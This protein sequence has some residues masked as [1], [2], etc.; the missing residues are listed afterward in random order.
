MKE[1]TATILG[2]SGLIGGKLLELLL[3][4]NYYNVI[5]V[6]VRRPVE[7]NNPAVRIMVI[8]FSDEVSFK[9]AIAGSD[10]LFCAVGTTQKKVEGDKAAYYKVDYDIPVNAARFCKETGCPVF[11]L[12]S[13]VGADSKSKNFYLKLKGEVEDKLREMKIDSVSVFRPSMLLGKRNE[14]RFT[15]EVAKAISSPLSFIFPSKYKP[16]KAENVAGAMIAASK[17]A[18]PGF[19]IYHYREMINIIETS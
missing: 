4:D 15:E 17:K 14:Y 18:T 7:F 16:I 11:L 8:D 12:V 19:N 1:K 2:S 3:N 10:A 5:H 13:S 9:S 6:I